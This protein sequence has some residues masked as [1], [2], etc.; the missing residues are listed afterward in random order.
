MKSQRTNG[1]RVLAL[2]VLVGLAAS[3]CGDDDSTGPTAVSLSDLFGTQLIRADGSTVGVGVL[4]SVPLIGIYFANPGCPACGGF[5]PTLVDAYDQLKT[6]QKP[7]EIVLASAGITDAA[8][9]DY[10]V[11]SGMGWLAIPPQSGKANSLAQ[12]YN[13]RWVPTLIIIDDELATITFTGREEIAQAGA[14][15]YDVWLAASGG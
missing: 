3:A 13:V 15:I 1:W 9:L 10:M 12:R 11:D 14:D 7:F 6:D 8:L 5:N 2:A 4:N